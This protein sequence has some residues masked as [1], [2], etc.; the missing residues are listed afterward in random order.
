MVLHSSLR[1]ED[2]RFE[3]IHGLLDL[4]RGEGWEC[5]GKLRKVQSES[6][7]T[8]QLFLDPS[9][10][11]GPVVTVS[12]K[13]HC[14]R[15]CPH[16]TCPESRQQFQNPKRDARCW[17]G[18]REGAHSF[19][20]KTGNGE[21]SSKCSSIPAVQE[22]TWMMWAQRGNTGKVSEWGGVGVGWVNRDTLTG[23]KNVL[24]KLSLPWTDREA[25]ACQEWCSLR[26]HTY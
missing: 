12:E 14:Q 22:M 4:S 17:A 10:F 6:F 8:I 9:E 19:I 24:E 11:W 23:V 18:G 3:D 20:G 25:T 7:H 5:D 26:Q 21:K 2:H 13:K 1:Q 15:T 16:R